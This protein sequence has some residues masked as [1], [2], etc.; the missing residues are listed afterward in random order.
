VI[1]M[2]LFCIPCLALLIYFLVMGTFF[3]R[4]RVYIKDGY[5]CF[6]DKLRGKK[7]ALSFDNR[8]RL[9]FSAW[10]T[11]H[12]MPWLGRWFSNQRNFSNFLIISTIVTTVISIYFIWLFIYWQINPICYD[13][14][15]CVV[16]I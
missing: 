3:P 4:Y 6:T 13:G 2:V 12:R 5:R 9:A 16:D 11:Q 1:I 14:S 8:M 15:S 10:L 7:C